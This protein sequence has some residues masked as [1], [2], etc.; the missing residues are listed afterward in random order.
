MRTGEP[1]DFLQFYKILLEAFACEVGTSAI[2]PVIIRH[3]QNK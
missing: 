2:S 3:L 1:D